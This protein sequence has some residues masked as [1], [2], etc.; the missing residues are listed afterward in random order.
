MG[1]PSPL[2]NCFSKGVVNFLE[3]RGKNCHEGRLPAMGVVSCLTILAV[4]LMP[5]QRSLMAI[6]ALNLHLIVL[7]HSEHLF[8]ACSLAKFEFCFPAQLVSPQECFYSL[9][10]PIWTT[11]F[12]TRTSTVTLAHSRDGS[13]QNS[14]IYTHAQTQITAKMMTSQ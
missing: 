1:R 10:T 4:E 8:S 13:Q 2:A 11:I 9:P 3:L 6:Q 14:S 12:S 7:A 5:Q